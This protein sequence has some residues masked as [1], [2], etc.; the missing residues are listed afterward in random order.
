LDKAGVAPLAVIGMGRRLSA[1]AASPALP[2]LIPPLHRT[3]DE[4]ARPGVSIRS[5]CISGSFLS[6]FAGIYP[7]SFGVTEKHAT[8]RPQHRLL[9]AAFSRAM[10]A[11]PDPIA[12]SMA[13]P[14][15]TIEG[16]QSRSGCLANRD[17]LRN[18]EGTWSE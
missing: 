15:T 12:G 8:V 2:R 7:E 5:V 13:A 10:G 18:L 1:D 4:Y 6:D 9:P 16:S 17:L 14:L 11:C 3:T